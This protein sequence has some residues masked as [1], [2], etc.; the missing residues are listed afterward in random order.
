MAPYTGIHSRMY[1]SLRESSTTVRYLL[2]QDASI[3]SQVSR[4]RTNGLCNTSWIPCD[5]KNSACCKREQRSSIWA[6]PV[7][8]TGESMIEGST[9][10]LRASRRCLHSILAKSL[11]PASFSFSSDSAWRTRYTVFM[12]LCVLES[13]MEGLFPC[14]GMGSKG[15]AAADPVIIGAL[16]SLAHQEFAR[17]APTTVRS[18]SLEATHSVAY[19]C[20]AHVRSFVPPSRHAHRRTLLRRG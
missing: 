10:R 11:R 17:R 14:A 6:F 19:V 7:W 18:G 16:Q 13:L 2:V 12:S 8:L 20:Y 4:A 9:R 5:F 15:S 1:F 3:P